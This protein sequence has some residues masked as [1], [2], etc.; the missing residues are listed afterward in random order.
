VEVKKQ[1]NLIDFFGNAPEQ[2]SQPQ[3][4]AFD[5][6]NQTAPAQQVQQVQQQFDLLSFD[7]K[8]QAQSFDIFG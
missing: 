7:A 4:F 1:E 8:P 5:F 2:T 6:M 3:T